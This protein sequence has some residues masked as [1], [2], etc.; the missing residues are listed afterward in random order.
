MNIFIIVVAHSLVCYLNWNMNQ[1]INIIYG[2]IYVVDGFVGGGFDI[3]WII[4]W[5]QF[6][7]TPSTFWNV[8]FCKQLNSHWEKQSSEMSEI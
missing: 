4:N 3:Q 8:L 1:T 6:T 7:W 2:E 5:N